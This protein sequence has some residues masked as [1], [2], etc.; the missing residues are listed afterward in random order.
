[1]K[2]MCPVHRLKAIKNKK[3]KKPSLVGKYPQ[4]PKTQSQRRSPNTERRA[5]HGYNHSKIYKGK[6]I[7]EQPLT[8]LL[9]RPIQ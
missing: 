9:C 6:L 8:S 5:S 3:N 2:K 4:G 1:M 7:Q